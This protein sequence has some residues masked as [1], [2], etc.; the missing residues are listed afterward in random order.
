[1]DIVGLT[2]EN[3]YVVDLQALQAGLHGV[4]DMLQATLARTRSGAIITANLPCG[5]SR[6]G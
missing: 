3:V 2:L 6:T 5:S 1:M 4:E